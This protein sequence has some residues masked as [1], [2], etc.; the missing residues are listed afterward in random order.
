[1]P[2]LGSKAEM[3]NGSICFPLFS[4]QRTLRLRSGRSGNGNA[5]STPILCP[6]TIRAP[7]RLV[8]VEPE[9]LR[10]KFPGRNKIVCLRLD[11]MTS[12]LT[13]PSKW[14]RQ[15]NDTVEA[16][17]A[18]PPPHRDAR[19][20]ALVKALEGGARRNPGCS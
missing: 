10:R 19:H 14:A 9:F 17:K 15:T 4:R 12:T 11:F 6:A 5:N 7:F 20:E 13:M 1:M 3:L 18:N 2:A 16:G 8:G